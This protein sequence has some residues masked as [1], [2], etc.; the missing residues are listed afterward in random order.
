MTTSAQ[1]KI[2]SGH[3]TTS[4]R[5]NLEVTPLAADLVELRIRTLELDL[6]AVLS[7]AHLEALEAALAEARARMAAGP[8]RDTTPIV[9]RAA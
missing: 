8:I 4:S 7:G 6:E 5:A 2:R 1:V 9:V 3:L